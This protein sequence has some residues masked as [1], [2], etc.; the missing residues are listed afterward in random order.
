MIGHSVTMRRLMNLIERTA[1]STLPVIITGET[2]TGKEVTARAIHDHSARQGSFVTVNCAAIPE[3]LIESELFGH[4]RGSFHRCGSPPPGVDR[5]SARRDA[6][7]GRD[8]GDAE[9][10]AG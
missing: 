1:T 7:S 5:T 2:G 3:T 6:F 4:E 8:H 9:R 10:F